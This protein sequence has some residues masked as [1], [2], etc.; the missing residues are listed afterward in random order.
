MND[1][2]P[3]QVKVLAKAISI[4]EVL[5]NSKEG[6]GLTFIS[7]QAQVNKATTYRILSTF[8][9][10]NIVEQGH[11]QGTYRL[12]I[13]LLE[14]GNSVQRRI[15]LRQRSLPELTRLSQQTEDTVFLCTMNNNKAVCIERLEGR[16]V[17]I[18]SVNIGDVWPIYLGAA[19][20]AILAN[21]PDYKVAEVLSE[22]IIPKTP[23]SPTNP[24][25]IIQMIEEIREKGYSICYEGVTN[26]VV[27]IR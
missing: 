25:V 3:D 20:L 4:L 1:S 15:D 19:S 8:I 5:Q 10:Y 21:L 9:N 17:N 23:K 12:G 16:H 6:L 18:L 22:P 11:K 7:D 14:L 26:G 13:R 2:K 27:R 24:N